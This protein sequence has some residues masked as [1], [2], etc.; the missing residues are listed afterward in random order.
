MTGSPSPSTSTCSVTSEVTSSGTG[1]RLP[2]PALHHA[3]PLT[4]AP[5]DL[6]NHEDS[7]DRGDHV[8]EVGPDAPGDPVHEL[9]RR[10]REQRLAGAVRRRGRTALQ[11]PTRPPGAPPERK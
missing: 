9:L 4:L 10:V 2:M 7:Q 5:V 11:S 1:N 3:S 6:A 8:G